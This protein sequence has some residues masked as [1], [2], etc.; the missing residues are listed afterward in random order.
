ML[1]SDGLVMALISAMT[2]MI[3][4]VA[5][6]AAPFILLEIFWPRG[7]R[8]SLESR[9]R[10]GVIWVVWVVVATLTVAPVNWLLGHMQVRPLFANLTPGFLAGLPAI[11]ATAVISALLADLIQYWVHRAQH[12][13]PF[14]WR[15]HAVHHSVRELGAASQYRHVGETFFAAILTGIATPFLYG[16]QTPV[17]YL[18]F[19]LGLQGAYLHSATGLNFGPLNRILIDN[20][21][22]R[23]HH[24]LE[25]AH[26]NRNFSNFSPIWDV[27]FGTA[28]FPKRDEWPDT[29][30]A[31]HP[32]PA[33]IVD[34]LLGPF[35]GLGARAASQADAKASV[36]G[37]SR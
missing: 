24:S 5:I 20:R 25:P 30:L 26:F 16:G 6:V 36:P 37:S 21:F 28:Y 34:Y 3:L 33:A 19:L 11:L 12:G 31:D 9:L 13:V 8:I 27:V 4:N 15:F 35:R 32:E 22:H 7:A 1:G 29:G 2:G 23:I 10:A 18:V 14:L 17:P